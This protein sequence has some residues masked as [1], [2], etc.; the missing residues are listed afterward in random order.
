MRYPIVIHKDPDSDYGVTVPDLPVASQAETPWRKPS[1]WR[2][3]PLPG[4][5]ETLLMEE[6]PIPE[7]RPMQVHQG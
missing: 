1:K 7:L 2:T 5:I 3:K 4:H 6:L